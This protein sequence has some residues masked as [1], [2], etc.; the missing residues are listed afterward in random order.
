MPD[1][2]SK[3]SGTSDPEHIPADQGQREKPPAD[4][5][6]GDLEQAEKSLEAV[7][8]AA[9]TARILFFTFLLLG[10]YI[11]IIIGSTTD[12]QLLRVSPVTLPLLNVQ[13]PI[14]VFYAFVP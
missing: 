5:D 12:E 11:G 8:N 14:R 1:K 2:M 13:L 9:S 3:E 4:A 10:T 6:K 7:N